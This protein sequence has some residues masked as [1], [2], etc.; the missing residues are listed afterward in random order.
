MVKSCCMLLTERMPA[1]VKEIL[2][3]IQGQH[4]TAMA[5]AHHKTPP[6]PK[7][8][9]QIEKAALEQDWSLIRRWE[10][11]TLISISSLAHWFPV[12]YTSVGIEGP[13]HMHAAG[14]S[15]FVWPGGCGVHMS[16]EHL[17]LLP[18]LFWMT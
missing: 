15:L 5:Q 18:L 4:S 6:T 10:T 12:P 3:S 8:A 14:A 2:H 11:L 9:Q 1:S 17:E 13:L 7:P 16:G